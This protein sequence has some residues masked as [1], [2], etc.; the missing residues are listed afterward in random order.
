M[1]VHKQL[2]KAA[3]VPSYY[4]LNIICTVISTDK[5]SADLF[6][7]IMT[8]DKHYEVEI[9]VKLHATNLKIT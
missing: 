8:R 5:F 3:T 7:Y 2:I 6:L 9:L 1:H 4:P